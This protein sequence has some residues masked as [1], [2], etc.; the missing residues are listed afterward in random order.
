MGRIPERSRKKKLKEAARHWLN[1]G[2]A[3]FDDDDAAMLG[4]IEVEDKSFPIMQENWDA[5]T[6][7]CATSTQWRWYEANRIGLD[8]SA[9]KMLLDVYAIA[10]KQD[11]FERVRMM[12]V[13]VLSVS[14]KK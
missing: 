12:E 5:I 10:D 4:D 14:A 11:C 9:I 13:E 6:V 2:A 3:T 1:G 7:F 8:Y